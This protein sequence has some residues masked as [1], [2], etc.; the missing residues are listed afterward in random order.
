MPQDANPDVKALQDQ[1]KKTQL[2]YQMA[3]EMSQFKGGFLARTSHEIRS[4]LNSLIGLLQL[5]ISDLCDN[6][7]EE[8]EFVNQAHTSALK[9]VR[10][11][12]EIIAVAKTQHGTNQLE[13][14]PLQLT[15]V[16]EDV[17]SLTHLQAANR[18]LQL[19]LTPPDPEIYVLADARWLQQVLVNLVDAAI[20]KMEEGSIQ[21]SVPP[22]SGSEFVH[23]WIDAECPPSV[24][25]EPVD[26][27]KS[28]QKQEPLSKP[29]QTPAVQTPGLLSGLNLLSSQSLMEMMQGHLEIVS[30]EEAAGGST[31]Q[32]ITRIQCTIP[33]M[34]PENV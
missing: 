1:L 15:G 2:A 9:M 10:L 13:I 26:L 29:Q 11:I 22:L 24:W 14:Q 28:T 7:A 4:P 31:A 21:I 25:S 6:P 17:Y 33:L 23:V 12:D 3:T 19:Q 16:L 20:P 34:P 5:I 8:R 27:L 18:N 32:N 30:S